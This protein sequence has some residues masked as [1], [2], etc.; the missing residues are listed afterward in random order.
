MLHVPTLTVFF[1][2]G[3]E[4]RFEF[5]LLGL[6]GDPLQD[7]ARWG[8]MTQAKAWPLACPQPLC[9]ALQRP[10]TRAH[11]LPAPSPSS[12]NPSTKSCPSATPAPAPVL[13]C[14]WGCGEGQ[15]GDP[16]GPWEEASCHWGKR[17]RVPDTRGLVLEASQALGR[18]VPQ[19]L[20]SLPP[21][22]GQSRE[23]P[24]QSPLE[25]RVQGSVPLPC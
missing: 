25:Y 15:G 24:E 18:H 21:G 12:T 22:E 8:E 1:L 9:L 6:H 5:S 10:P 13:G 7:V 16:H 20:A 17:S 4:V 3:Q 11:D 14:L 23:G 19:P 2:K